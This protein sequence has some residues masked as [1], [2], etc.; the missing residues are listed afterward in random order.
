MVGRRRLRRPLM[1]PIA[2]RM[3]VPIGAVGAFGF[4]LQSRRLTSS[5][6]RQKANTSIGTEDAIPRCLQRLSL[7]PIMVSS[8]SLSAV[9]QT[10]PPMLSS[11]Q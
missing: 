10:S 4:H 1:R 9:K 11:D 5:G 8:Q 2:W 6:T 3:V 7:P